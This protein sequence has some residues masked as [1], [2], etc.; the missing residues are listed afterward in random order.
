MDK[1]QKFGQK[2]VQNKKDNDDLIDKVKDSYERRERVKIAGVNRCNDLYASICCCF[3]K[4][5]WTERHY[6]YSKA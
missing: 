6:A 4:K 5:K 2:L 3:F 1:A